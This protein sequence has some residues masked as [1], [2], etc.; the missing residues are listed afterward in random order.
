[1]TSICAHSADRFNSLLRI[2]RS[3]VANPPCFAVPLDVEED[4]HSI[5]IGFHVPAEKHAAVRVQAS[6]RSVTV[7][8][9]SRAMRVCA[10]PCSVLATGI[11][12][13]HSADMLRVRIPKK[14]PAKD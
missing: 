12:T 5:T 3:S 2:S 7:W 14:C 6:D 1:M 4:D 9:G 8:V 11:D 10:L 13:T